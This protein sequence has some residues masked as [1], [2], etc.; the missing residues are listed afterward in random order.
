MEFI[1]KN[2]K[3]KMLLLLFTILLT[4]SFMPINK[5]Y[6]ATTFKVSSVGEAVNVSQ[7]PSYADWTVGSFVANTYHPTVNLTTKDVAI[8]L[9]WT[10]FY[11]TALASA[12]GGAFVST[13]S[14]ELTDPVYFVDVQ[15]VGTT[16][17]KTIVFK[18]LSIGAH[19]ITVRALPITGSTV[20]TDYTN[21]VLNY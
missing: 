19:T 14:K 7:N 18:N 8:K 12:D 1:F 16:Y 6:A 10:G 15:Q 13:D 9:T 21:V 20:L 11:G 5:V 17:V 3:T 4:I 2:K